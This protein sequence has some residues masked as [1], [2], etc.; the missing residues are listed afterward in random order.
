[1]TKYTVV[2][3]PAWDDDFLYAGD[4]WKDFVCQDFDENVIILHN[5]YTQ[6]YANASWWDDAK[7]I[8][9][10]IYNGYDL[11]DG[12]YDEYSPDKL[13]AIQALYDA[14]SDADDPEFIMQ[15]AEILN[16]RL[17]RA[18]TTIHGNTQSDWND[19]IY[20]VGKVDPNILEDWYY[21]N[22]VEAR[23]YMRD[24]ADEL[25]DDED[26]Y[27]DDEDYGDDIDSMYLTSSEY[28]SIEGRGAEKK[29][30]EMFN[31]PEEE[32]TVVEEGF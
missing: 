4:E 3:R 16:P 18:T 13:E 8:I 29:F 22:I 1:M 20:V 21:G 30:A 19:V 12:D 32:L 28:W 10:A 27:E 7:Y 24:D 11:R 9:E 2:I 15:V 31:V 25:E 26:E 14:T 17:N 5:R 6:G 23:L